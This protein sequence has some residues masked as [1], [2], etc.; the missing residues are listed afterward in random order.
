MVRKYTFLFLFL[1]TGIALLLLQSCT[2][3]KPSDKCTRAFYYWRT[4]FRLSQNELRVLKDLNVTKLYT[5]FFDVEWNALNNT[6]EPVGKILFTGH[7][8][9][10]DIV[11][12]V[13]I[14]NKTLI[15]IPFDKLP[16]L[17]DKIVNLMRRISAAHS[18]RYKEIQIDCDWSDK[19]RFKY[20]SLIENI[21]SAVKVPVSVTI[22]LHQ[23]KYRNIT[24]IPPADRGMLMFYNMGNLKP[25]AQKNSIF[26]TEDA[27]K[28]VEYLDTY[29]LKMDV[30]LPFF[31][32]DVHSR[33][34]RIVNLLSK[35]KMININDEI[36]FQAENDYNFTAINSFYR[37]G[38]YFRKG[39]IIKREKLSD[40]EVTGAAEMVAEHLASAER[41]VVLF[42]LDEFNLAQFD[43]EIPEEIFNCFQ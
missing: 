26:N 24:G 21:R 35:D 2:G 12:V 40:K 9:A 19:T 23:I 39:D 10:V 37:N 1:L 17:T 28:Y 29:P 14:T 27:A 22:R 6:P 42:D 11:P 30:A 5:R 32:W 13:Y 4:E 36:N 41:T 38:N 33:G 43:D 31:S 3:N 25:E 16:E 34:K 20:F 7:P 15:N 8:G 18:I